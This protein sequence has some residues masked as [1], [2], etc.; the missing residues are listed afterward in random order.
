MEIK[1]LARSRRAR[2]RP[3]ILRARYASTRFFRHLIRHVF[4]APA[5]IR[6]GRPHRVAY[7][8]P[9]SDFD[10]NGWLRLGAGVGW[11]DRGNPAR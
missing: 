7:A 11:S 4:P 10:R 9:R 3:N 2:D 5:S 1:Q 6:A 8:P